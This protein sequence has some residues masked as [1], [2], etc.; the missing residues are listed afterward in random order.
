MQ[1]LY[2][3]RDLDI[4]GETD[5]ERSVR[6]AR[7]DSRRPPRG[8]SCPYCRRRIGRVLKVREVY[9][10]ECGAVHATFAHRVHKYTQHH[11]NLNAV[12]MQLYK[13][14][15]DK[16]VFENLEDMQTKTHY[17]VMINGR[18][19]T[20]RVTSYGP[21]YALSFGRSVG[22]AAA[23]FDT[24]P[25][26]YVHQ[27]KDLSALL[28]SGDARIYEVELPVIRCAAPVPARSLTERVERLEGIL[29]NWGCFSVTSGA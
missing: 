22:T 8:S 5:E 6:I 11:W 21:P 29:R 28:S 15:R 24:P 25:L 2:S 14:V 23:L 26:D 7:I 13:K 27:G 4:S 1:E 18:W 3:R 12:C 17:A 19:V 20:G 10:C 9:T 16:V